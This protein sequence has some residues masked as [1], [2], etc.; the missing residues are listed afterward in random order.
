MAGLYKR[1]SD[2]GGVCLKKKVQRVV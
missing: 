2:I 1:D